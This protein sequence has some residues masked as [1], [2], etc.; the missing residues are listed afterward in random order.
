MSFKLNSLYNDLLFSSSKQ[1][2]FNGANNPP[3]F[4]VLVA[5][6]IIIGIDVTALHVTISNFSLLL[7]ILIIQLFFP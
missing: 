1:L 6:S 4:I 7:I 5:S 3:T 2:D